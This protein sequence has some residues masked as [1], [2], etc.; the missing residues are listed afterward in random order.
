[1]TTEVKPQDKTVSANG[2]KINYLDWG[3]PTATPMVLL[4]GLRGHRHSWDDISAAFCRDYHVL[5]LDQRGR[6]ETDSAPDGNYTTEAFVADLE[7]F[8][9]ALGLDRFV[10]VGHSMGGRNSLV[11]ASRHASKL[12]KLVVVDVG[13]EMDPRGSQRITRELVEAP[14]EF[15]SFESLYEYMSK[16]NRFASEPVLRR[17][18]Q[19]ATRQLPGGKIGWQYDPEIRESRRRGDTAPQMDLWPE[20]PKIS[21]PTL[22]IRGTDTDV[23]APQTA[24]RMIDELPQGR[25]VEV[26]MAGHMV[27]EDNP[28]DT[29]AAMQAFLG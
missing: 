9:D 24:S 27:F 18:L 21:C 5:A 8:C 6:G 3:N 19:Y 12:E 7:G 28:Q 16:Q 11:Y 29:I 15:D 25:L 14:D 17:R 23:L 20:L 2:I 10:L 13:P 22:V 1:M 4:H 26:P